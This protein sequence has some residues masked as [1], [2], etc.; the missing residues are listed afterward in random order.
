MRY[1]T[2]CVGPRSRREEHQ[3]ASVWS[4]EAE[5][6]AASLEI[7]DRTSVLRDADSLRLVK[8]DSWPMDRLTPTATE[9]VKHWQPSFRVVRS[10]FAPR[11]PRLADWHGLW[12]TR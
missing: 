1:I 9:W 6:V 10:I 2:T 4:E 12:S 5:K 7:R 3:R 11:P 8:Q